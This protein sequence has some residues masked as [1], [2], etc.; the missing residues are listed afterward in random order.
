MNIFK[1]GLGIVLVVLAVAVMLA[2]A[3]GPSEAPP[4]QPTPSTP[5]G[6]QPPEIS[7]LTANPSGVSYGGSA[8]V[9]CIATDPDGDVIDYSWSASG[10]DISGDGDTVTWIAPDKG[11]NFYIS[12]ILSDGKGGETT[13]K[14]MVTVSAAVSTVTITP[15]AEETGT[16]CSEGGGDNFRTWAGDD[17][18]DRGYCAFWS[19]DVRSLKG[20]NIQSASLKFTTKDVVGEPF[21]ST[22]G[23]GGLSLW[24]VK[25]DD[26]LP[27]FHYTG[28]KL[29][30]VP[31]QNTPPTVLDITQEIVN[32]AAAMAA[33]RFQVEALFQN[34][35]SN[36]N[37]VAQFIEWSEVVLEVT[38]SDK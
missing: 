20:K 38:Y 6:N 33:P 5:T 12:V 10:G 8:T 26:G 27:G 28:S 37:H 22:T 19:F 9:K 18:K 17:E 30:K 15:V 34:R 4:T 29:I 16:V 35:V 25:Y 24:K 36:G 3:C 13:D 21:P 11:G 23:L 2:G 31:V 1:S 32:V 14:V 7:S